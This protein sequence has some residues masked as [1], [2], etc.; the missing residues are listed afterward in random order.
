MACGQGCRPL[1]STPGGSPRRAST[2]VGGLGTLPVG[3]GSSTPKPPSP[4]ELKGGEGLATLAH[5]TDSLIVQLSKGELD[6]FLPSFL[7]GQGRHLKK[8]PS[9]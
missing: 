1:T 3:L 6:M 7:R 5:K 8:L 2:K 9:H 4:P